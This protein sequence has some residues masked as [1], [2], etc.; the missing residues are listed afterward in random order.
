MRHK[1]NQIAQLEVENTSFSSNFY[2][3]FIKNWKYSETR[4]CL[5]LISIPL[6]LLHFH[7]LFFF[8]SSNNRKVISL[9]L[10]FSFLFRVMSPIEIATW[11]C[12]VN[13]ITWHAAG[14]QHI[15]CFVL[16][17]IKEM[18]QARAGRLESWHYG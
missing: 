18:S 8:F 2:V 11:I 12:C 10:S 16:F 17:L 1:E 14:T 15:C 4:S 5:M 7:L 3:L 13:E 6:L 9:S